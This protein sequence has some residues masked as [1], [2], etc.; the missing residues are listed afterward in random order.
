M[1]MGSVCS[2]IG[3]LELGLEWAGVGETAWQVEIDAKCR[4]VL[5]HH[6]PDATLH[7]DIREVYG[8][9]RLKK[10]TE[11]QVA[12]AVSA[13]VGG[14]S[15]QTIGTALGVSRQAMWDLLRHRTTLRSQL[16]H[17]EDERAHD[18]VEL[19]LE[20]GELVRPPTCSE[21]GDGGKMADGRTKIQAHH[22]DYNKPTDVRWLCQRC[23]HEWLKTH[24]A[25][26]RREVPSELAAVDLICGGFP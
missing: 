6:W 10:L 11:D 13:Y 1:R 2:G 22:D 20:K 15:L 8:M 17:G 24:T 7:E 25:V 18:I 23:H 14:S 21:C 26:A 16:R 12:H 5:A 3:G 4:A 19:A 9:T